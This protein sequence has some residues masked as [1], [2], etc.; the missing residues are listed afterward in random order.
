VKAIQTRYLRPTNCRGSRIK[1]SDY[2]GNAITVPYDY[3]SVNPH[4][5][6]AVALIHKMGW[7]PVTIVQGQLKHG[8]VFV[9]L[10]TFSYRVGA[11]DAEYKVD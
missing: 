1:A 9:L 2:D 6:A 4:R 3:G 10:N 11:D 7:V 8:D 5:E